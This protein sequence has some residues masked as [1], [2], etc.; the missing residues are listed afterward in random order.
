MQYEAEE[1]NKTL[2]T[3]LIDPQLPVELGFQLPV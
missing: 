3:K 1:L 2:S